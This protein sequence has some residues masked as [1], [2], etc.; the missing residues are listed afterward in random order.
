MPMHSPEA[1]QLRRTL[2]ADAMDDVTGVYEA[3]WSA[4]SRWPE[5]RPSERLRIVEEAAQSALDEG[6]VRIELGSWDDGTTPVD[7]AEARRLLNEWATWTIPAGPKVF[8][9]RTEKGTEYVR[10]KAE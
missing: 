1:E 5:K 3:W 6:L 8:V 9:W 10:R 7:D 2:I 4:N